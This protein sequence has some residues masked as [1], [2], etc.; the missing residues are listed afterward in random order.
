[1]QTKKSHIRSFLLRTK[2]K[3]ECLIT[4][5]NRDGWIQPWER[6]HKWHVQV[7][8]TF[9]QWSCLQF[10]VDKQRFLLPKKYTNCQTG[11]TLKLCCVANCFLIP[12]Q[13]SQITQLIH[14]PMN[15]NESVIYSIQ[16]RWTEYNC[17]DQ[18]CHIFSGSV[19]ILKCWRGILSTRLRCGT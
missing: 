6:V 13:T 17:R 11:Y 14:K 8:P 18:V 19:G 2:L 5:R 7:I 15:T 1:M 4:L 9:N 16:Y 3:A 10:V 12:C